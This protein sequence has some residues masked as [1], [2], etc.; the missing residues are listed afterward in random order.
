VHGIQERL[1]GLW[2][3]VAGG[4]GKTGHGFLLSRAGTDD[5]S[6]GPRRSLFHWKG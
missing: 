3:I 2:N 5:R 1:R 6:H 4:D